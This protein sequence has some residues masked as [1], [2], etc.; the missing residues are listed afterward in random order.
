MQTLVSHGLQWDG[1]AILQS[2]HL[3]QYQSSL[4][5]LIAAQKVFACDC[6][7]QQV[8]TNGPYYQGTCRTKHITQLPHALRFINQQHCDGFRDQRLGWVEVDQQAA[9]EDFI[10]RRKDGLFAYHLA[11]VSDDIRMGISEIVR[12]ED[13]L[14][15]SA[16]QIA[17][18]EAL[19][20]PVPKFVHLPLV[21]FADGRKYSKQNYAPPLDNS[22]AA[23]NLCAALG[24][25]G[26]E[27]PE[28][29]K[30]EECHSVI[31]WALTK[32]HKMQG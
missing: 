1:N 29:L 26:C 31:D 3:A 23:S 19:G 16:C 8:K 9:C 17:L 15:P 5:A 32:W 2:Q 24:Y 20:A 12:G 10:L 28:V 4:D 14:L 27:P 25:L 11:S 18:F 6:T 30:K 7:R 22:K 21:M 13:L